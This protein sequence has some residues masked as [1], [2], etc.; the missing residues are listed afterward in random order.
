[1]PKRAQSASITRNGYDV[2]VRLGEL[3][4]DA[5]T[6]PMGMKLTGVTWEV[7]ATP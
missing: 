5:Y 1:M 6:G 3:V 4:H 2:V 7:V